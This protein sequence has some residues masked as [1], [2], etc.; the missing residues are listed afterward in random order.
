MQE[1]YHCLWFLWKCKF[2]H[3]RTHI[4]QY[5][6]APA[7]CLNWAQFSISLDWKCWLILSMGC[8]I[9][10]G[11]AA[12]LLYWD[13]VAD[14]GLKRADPAHNRVKQTVEK[15]QTLLHNV[16]ALILSVSTEHPQPL[17]LAFC[18]L[19]VCLLSLCSTQGLR[20]VVPAWQGRLDPACM[21]F[22]PSCCILRL[23]WTTGGGSNSTNTSLQN[24]M[25]SSTTSLL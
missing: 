1:V 13:T 16:K 4:N 23:F 11:D 10:A 17:R 25:Q 7:L 9:S 6:H 3:T 22:L 19:Y 21:V 18:Q 14:G 15:L 12:T 2:T 20:L 24:L 8:Q 5:S